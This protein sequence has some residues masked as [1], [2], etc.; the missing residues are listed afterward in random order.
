MEGTSEA[1]LGS[2]DQRNLS[3][4]VS[5]FLKSEKIS[6]LLY[7]RKGLEDTP[8][9]DFDLYPR[10]AGLGHRSQIMEGLRPF[11]YSFD[12]SSSSNNEIR[13][14]LC[15]NKIQVPVSSSPILQKKT[16]NKIPGSGSGSKNQTW[17]QSASWTLIC[18]LTTAN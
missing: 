18:S 7:V 16:K 2:S 4:S 12:S 6:A 9:H 3:G 13:A 17:F 10:P 8:F 15:C 14:V 1:I 11:S 5:L